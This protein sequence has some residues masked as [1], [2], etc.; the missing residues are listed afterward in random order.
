MN[1]IAIDFETAVGRDSICAVGLVMV[2]NGEIVEEYH[3]LIKPPHN[4]YNY[5]NTMV[6]GMTS[7]TTKNSPTFK[8]VYPEIKKII[9][10]KK[11]VAHNE[12][13]DRNALIKTMI[14]N[15]LDYNEL[16]LSD[17]WQCTLKIFR[18]KG[19]KPCKLSDL[20]QKFNIELNHHEA[21]SDARACAKLYIQHLKE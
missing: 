7:E 13:F 11:L 3:K 6:H 2:K 4:M 19:F 17:K 14:L 8:E 9:A 16:L 15:G 10:G 12:S 18:A 21:L 5:H 1:F 20:A